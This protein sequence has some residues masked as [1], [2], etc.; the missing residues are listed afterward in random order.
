MPY[1]LILPV[2]AAL[3][4]AEG[5]ALAVCAAVPRLRAA[6]PYGR[7]VL[8]GSCA[9]FFCA[10]AAS[11]LIAL[12]AVAIGAALGVTPDDRGAQLVAAF[13]LLGVFLGPFVAS[14]LGFLCGAWVGLKRARRARV[15]AG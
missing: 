13:V 12:V 15:V 6:L 14:P 9:G 10:N 2:F 4:A 1:F 8:L 5:L 7:R 11:A 3:F